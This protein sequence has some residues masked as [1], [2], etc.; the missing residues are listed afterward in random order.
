MLNIEQLYRENRALAK[1]AQSRQKTFRIKGYYNQAYENLQ[2]A[3][4]MLDLGSNPFSVKKSLS[5]SQLERQNKMLK[6]FV[7][8][9]TFAETKKEILNKVDKSKYSKSE[10]DAI[11]SEYF[12]MKEALNYS[13]MLADSYGSKFIGELFKTNRQQGGKDNDKLYKAI[14]DTYNEIEKIQKTSGRKVAKSRMLKKL[15]DKIDDDI[16]KNALE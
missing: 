14:R 13:N 10:Q 9:P 11:I 5:A 7:S 3:F 15:A 8:K 6:R 12:D 2:N 1:T 16:Y 4:D